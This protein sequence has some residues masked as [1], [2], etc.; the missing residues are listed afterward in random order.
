[1]AY[2]K[3]T[4][5]TTSYVNPTRMNHI[6]DGIEASMTWNY[7]GDLT[8]G[9]NGVDVTNY[10]DFLIIPLTNGTTGYNSFYYVRPRVNGAY[11]TFFETTNKWVGH[12]ILS[13]NQLSYV[14]D[15]LNGWRNI[16][17]AIYA[18]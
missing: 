7:L 15:L 9:G 3:Q 10:N 16:N 2:S 4:W 13:N 14:Q 6:E 18:K 17:L 1:M 8:D 12:L 5:D 11:L